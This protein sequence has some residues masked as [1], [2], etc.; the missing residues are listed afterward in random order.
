[1][2]CHVKRRGG[3]Q[4]IGARTNSLSNAHSPRTEEDS[5]RGRNEI[6]SCQGGEEAVHSS[7]FN[8]E[9][10]SGRLERSRVRRQRR[11]GRVERYDGGLVSKGGVRMVR[12]D[13][14]SVQVEVE[15]YT[16]NDSGRG[17]REVGVG[18][19]GSRLEAVTVY[20]SSIDL[21]GRVGFGK[22]WRG[23]EGGGRR[24]RNRQPR[25]DVVSSSKTSSVLPS[26]S[27]WRWLSRPGL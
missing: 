5:I 22:R 12:V 26:A 15:G 20:Q 18:M 24:R 25:T 9:E 19:R 4:M 16:T 8:E 27:W 3:G 6:A 1:M 13:K 11:S 10:R 2:T 17:W 21:R 7:A 14:A 23:S